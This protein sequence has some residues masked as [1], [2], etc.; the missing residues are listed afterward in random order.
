MPV[1]MSLE[2]P[3]YRAGFMAALQLCHAVACRS[4]LLIPDA[5]TCFDFR[6][7]LIAV[8]IEALRGRYFLEDWESVRLIC[9]ALAMVRNYT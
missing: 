9:D 6:P 3:A 4:M 2:S 7:L 8:L 5:R 1:M